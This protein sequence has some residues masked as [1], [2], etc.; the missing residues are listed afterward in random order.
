MIQGIVIFYFMYLN[1]N[2][3]KMVL[4]LAN[5][6]LQKNSNL[7]NAEPYFSCIIWRGKGVQT[8]G[9][10]RQVHLLPSNT[11]PKLTCLR[12]SPILWLFCRSSLMYCSFSCSV[13]LLAICCLAKPSWSRSISEQSSSRWLSC[14]PSTVA[15][16]LSRA[17]LSC[18]RVYKG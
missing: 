18:C 4:S 6:K 12:S 16:F 2:Y 5:F 7:N 17:C 15:N 1:C 14:S 11:K 9:E 10:R 13:F 8:T 3:R